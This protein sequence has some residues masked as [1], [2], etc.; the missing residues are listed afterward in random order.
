MSKQCNECG[1]ILPK[2]A[3]RATCA[4]CRKPSHKRVPMRAIYNKQQSDQRRREGKTALISPA[5]AS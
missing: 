2:H 5:K 4:T 3:Y 1:R